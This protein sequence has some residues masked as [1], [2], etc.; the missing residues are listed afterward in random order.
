M[1]S[2]AVEILHSDGDLAPPE[3]WFDDSEPL[4]EEPFLVVA[5]TGPQASGKSTLA[6]A[7]FDTTFPVA[8]RS[9]VG[10]ATTKGILAERI[11]TLPRPTLILDVEG[12]DARS[13][14]RDSKVFAAQAAAF[15]SALADVVI[16]NLWFNDACRLDSAAYSLIRAIL[17]TSSQAL[18]DGASVRT[19]LIVAV[20]DVDD[21]S[22]DA[23]GSLRDL[24]TKDVRLFPP[25]SPHCL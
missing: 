19:A 24:I 4:P 16:V 7:I 11:S 25:T 23:A 8:S 10:L 14:G 22:M 9:A 21:N 1:S 2:S 17:N 20:R 15:V 12:A 13:R 5:I 3:A 6:N 18:V